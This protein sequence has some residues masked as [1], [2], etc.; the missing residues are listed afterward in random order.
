MKVS[1]LNSTS[2]SINR[3]TILKG[4]VALGAAGGDLATFAQALAQ[5]SSED[6][7]QLTIL[8]QGGPVADTINNVALPIFKSQYPGVAIQLEV[9]ANAAA[10]PKMLAQRNN[11]V[12][13]GG[14]FN[15]LFSAR[16]SI[17]KM[18]AAINP[19]YMPNAK[20]VPKDLLLP[21]GD[22]VTFQQTPFGIMYNPDRVE[23]PT[24]WTDLWNPKYEGRVA[25]WDT[26]FD[27]YA[28]AAVATG[29]SPSVEDGVKA[30]EP[31]R[32][33]IGVWSTSPIAEEDMVHRGE[34]WLAPHWG[35]WCEQARLQGKRVAFAFPKEGATLWSNQLQSCV[36]FSPKVTELVQR[37]LNVWLSD[38]CQTA[39]L[40]NALISPAV[41]SLAIPSELQT[42]PAVISAGDAGKRLIRLDARQVAT[43]FAATKAL[44][45]RTLKS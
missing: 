9:S 14:M 43:K 10:Y 1:G 30:W 31:Y 39:W 32:K 3:R 29:K 26:Y 23:P 41:G 40:K 25:M 13:S 11:P 5:S 4:L 21:G 24:S 27:A 36:G 2:E 7:S 18:W 19:E 37:Y 16:G 17:D 34:V 38:E 45:E 33:N 35:A 6:V 20:R 12:I 44:I 8:I 15:D 42:N 28:M 22:G